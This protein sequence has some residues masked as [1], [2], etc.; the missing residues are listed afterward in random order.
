MNWKPVCDYEGLYEVSNTGDV[1]SLDRRAKRG[2]ILSGRIL[3]P[4]TSQGGYL[5]LTLCKN[6]KRTRFAVH[7]LV[8]SAFVGPKSQGLEVNHK[9]GN[10]KNNASYNL[11][12]VTRQE[13]TIHASRVLGRMKHKRVVPHGSKSKHAK[14]N[15]TQVARIKQLIRNG[16]SDSAISEMYPV[17]RR[18]INWIRN[19]ATWA[20]VE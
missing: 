8:A 12:Y 20:H 17:S 15:E 9:D 18:A 13:N 5:Y 19:G 3:K 7:Q 4:W 1:R 14:L 16:A 10:K 6:G 11:E 2:A